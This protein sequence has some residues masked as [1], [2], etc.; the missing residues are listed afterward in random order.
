[1]DRSRF[2]AFAAAASLALLASR[3][4]NAS[5]G[6]GASGGG[7]FTISGETLKEGHW[8]VS[9]REDFTKFEHFSRSEAEGRA[10]R[11]GDFDT[12]DHG[13]I[14]SVDVAYGL[15]NDFQLSAGIGYF[16][17]RAFVGAERAADGSVESATADPSG[18]TDLTLTGKYRVLSGAPGN[19]AI[20]A[21]VKLPTGRDD[22]RLTN[23]ERL[24]PTDQPGT[25]AYDFPLGVAYSRYLTS[26]ITLDASTRYTFRTAHDR[27]RV[28]DRLD[29]G[30][31]LAYRRTESL[32]T[33]PQCSVFGE[34]SDVYLQKDTDHGDRDVNTG[35][36]TVYLSPGLRFRFSDNLAVTVAPAFPVIQHLNGEQGRVEFKLALAISFAF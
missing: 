20:L 11:G 26:R 17:G 15:T 10:S 29:S 14:T 24:S 4:A 31:A 19:L 32:K 6:P 33:F 9:V 30:V 34:L 27:F 3:P 16:V 8:E 35:S 1:M 22:V 36:N 23:G 28:G 21:G 12:L 2:I 5:H 13:F 25:G 7:S 18:L